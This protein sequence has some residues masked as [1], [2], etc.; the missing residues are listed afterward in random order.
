MHIQPHAVL[1]FY[2]L[3]MT[4][5]NTQWRNKEHKM[6]IVTMQKTKLNKN[7]RHTQTKEQNKNKRN[8]K[9]QQQNQKKGGKKETISATNCTGM[10][11]RGEDVY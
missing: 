6:V 8:K 7:T 9:K 5:K 3:A 11:T 1:S 4:N 10:Y 2:S